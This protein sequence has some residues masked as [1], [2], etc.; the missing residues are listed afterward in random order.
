[1]NLFRWLREKPVSESKCPA[2]PV[3]DAEVDVDRI[4]IARIERVGD[5]ATQF[6]L[7]DCNS[8]VVKCSKDCHTYFVTRFRNKLNSKRQDMPS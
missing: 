8:F 3:Y 5:G 2:M 6:V 7:H 4:D 1:M